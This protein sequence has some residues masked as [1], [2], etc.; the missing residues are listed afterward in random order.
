MDTI[1]QM[2]EEFAT[3]TLD[4]LNELYHQEIDEFS[5]DLEFQ[6]NQIKNLINKLI[7]NMENYQGQ[8]K[9]LTDKTIST[10]KQK[11]DLKKK[12]IYEDFFKLQNLINLF[13]YQ[14]IVMTYVHVDPLTGHRELRIF[15]ND[16]A[17]LEITEVNNYGRHYAKLG[18]EIKEKYLQ[19]KNSLSD[20]E[21]L[22]LQ[23]T[24]AEVEARYIKYKGR[25]LWK[26]NNDW[27]GYKLY[28][29][30]PIN[31]AFTDFYLHEVQLKN[32]LNTNLHQFMTS[33]KPQG[34]INADNANG[35]LIGDTSYGGLQMAV[36]GA[37]GSPQNFA[38]IIKWLKEIQ[39][40][41]FTLEAFQKFII[42]FK[43]IEQ[44]KATK[45]VK[46][47]TQRSIS[48]MLK[49]HGEN[50]TKPLISIIDKLD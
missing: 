10:T 16:I 19:L 42:R 35:F 37:Y 48:G 28:N 43:D 27:Y 50:L 38:M 45:L 11:L 8:S 23:M 9:L 36:K 15:D 24:A 25:I 22:G 17:H 7:I 46:P 1:A 2:S 4:E 30:G 12:M 33:E 3:I 47:L 21:N 31:E 41:N 49:Y 39:K 29:R 34:V 20:K 26:I 44:E 5:Q 14:K 18:Y 40:E 13:I 32:S 6:M